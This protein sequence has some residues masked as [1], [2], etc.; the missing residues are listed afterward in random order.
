MHRHTHSPRTYAHKFGD[1][2]Y[3]DGV[4]GV[5]LR[6][7][8]SVVACGFIHWHQNNARLT[9]AQFCNTHRHDWSRASAQTSRKLA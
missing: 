6:S 5:Y 2:G 9:L 4:C 3:D 7:F 1:H 8:V